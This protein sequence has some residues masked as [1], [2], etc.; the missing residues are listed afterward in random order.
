MTDLRI[1]RL[2]ALGKAHTTETLTQ[3][4]SQTVGIQAQQLRQAEVGLALQV[5]S[6]TRNEL[7]AAYDSGVVVRVWAQRWTY[8][9]MTQADWA[10]VIAARLNEQLP[11]AY[12]QGQQTLF[13][14]LATS[15]TQYLAT[16]DHISQAEVD[17]YLEKLAGKTLL[18]QE[19]Y[20]ILQ[21]VAHTGAFTFVPKA[22]NQYEL[23]VQHVSL[24][25]PNTA[26]TQL[27][28]RYL[29]GFGPASIND[30][31]K[32]AGLTLSRVK[33]LW[34]HAAQD[35]V[36]VGNGL[37]ALDL[38][39]TTEFPEVVLTAGFDAAMTGYADKNW[40]TDLTHQRQLWTVN[41]ILKPLVIING[42]VV[43]TWHFKVQG[44]KMRAT[45]NAWAPLTSAQIGKLTAKLQHVAQFLNLTLIFQP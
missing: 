11:T 30:F 21:L 14:T 5:P 35:W 32:W 24:V 4:L 36:D 22:G 20:A 18:P 3:A 41:G 8:Q 7:V 25:A 33:P 15:L 40:L 13:K 23:R 6:L 16:I 31:C 28:P 39:A 38:P 37:F 19:R 9:L 27:M 43:G 45:L 26:I 2:A 17:Y 42:A 34:Q 1:Q 12:F 10:L 44:K 29:A